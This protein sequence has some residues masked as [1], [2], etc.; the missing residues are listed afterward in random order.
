MMPSEMATAPHNFNFRLPTFGGA[1]SVD[2]LCCPPLLSLTA[3]RYFD[4]DSRLGR[5]RE[6]QPLGDDGD[7]LGRDEVGLVTPHRERRLDE[8]LAEDVAHHCR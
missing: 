6:G 2:I 4:Q 8:G 5:P 1:V 3:A 7:S